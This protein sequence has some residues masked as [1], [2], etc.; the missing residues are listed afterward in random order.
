MSPNV[1]NGRA[2][3]RSRSWR[4]RSAKEVPPNSCDRFF[5]ATEYGSWRLSMWESMTTS[6]CA[7]ATAARLARFAPRRAASRRYCAARYVGCCLRPAAC[8]ASTKA[9]RRQGR[10]LRV[11]PLWRLPARA[12]LPGHRPAH[13]AR[14]PALGN[15]RLSVPISA[16]I[17]SAVR[18]PT[19]GTVC[20]R[21]LCASLSVGARVR[22]RAGRPA[23]RPAVRRT[24]IST[25]SCSMSW[26]RASMGARG[27]RGARGAG[28]P[29]G[30]RSQAALVGAEVARQR[31]RVPHWG[32]FPRTVPRAHGN[33]AHARGVGGARHPREHHGMPRRAGDVPHHRRPLDI[34]AFQGLL[35]AIPLGH[36]LIARDVR[37]RVTSRSSRCG[38]GGM[39]LARR[40]PPPPP[41]PAAA[42]H[43]AASRRSTPSRPQRSCG[44]APP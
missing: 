42:R 32:I 43:A 22:L 39:K 44:P 18:W 1:S 16:T 30:T 6:E 8:A 41:R 36:P 23:G 40:T 35:Q 28:V 7:T 27:A 12:W 2:S 38:R 19:P 4:S 17:T 29:G 20:N 13:E 10:P 21:R 25:P 33:G 26:S 15:R 14:C 5:M 37:S 11:R 9:A 24:A 34:G 31:A 3:R